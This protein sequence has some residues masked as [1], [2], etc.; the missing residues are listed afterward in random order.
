MQKKYWFV[1]VSFIVISQ[2]AGLLGTLFTAPAIPEWYATLTLPALA[3]PNWIFGPV[4][5]TLYIFMGIAA[6]IVWRERHSANTRTALS[7]FFVQLVLNALW[8]IIFFGM[9]SPA[10]AFA[11]LCVLWSAIIATIILFRRI[12]RTAAVLLVPYLLWVTFA[13]YLNYSIWMLNI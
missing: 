8:S 2:A 11:E 4:W 1:L 5:T 9:Q 12:S 6:F 7:V 10:L 3:P 13:G